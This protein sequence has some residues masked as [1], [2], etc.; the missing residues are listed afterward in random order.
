LADFDLK[1]LNKILTDFMK[2]LKVV[3]VYPDNN[4]IPFKLKESFIDRF[5]DF[6]RD[7]GDL[8]LKIEN[9]CL[10]MD[11]QTVYEEDNP[12]ESL[13]LFFHYSG[14]NE[15]SFSRTFGVD[16]ANEFFKVI[17]SFINKEEGGDDL[18]SLLWQAEIG[19][20]DYRTIED[21]TLGNYD[22][23]F[24][25]FETGS[26]AGDSG[27]I[28]T[29]ENRVQYASIFL[30]EDEFDTSD[31]SIGI[32]NELAD[33]K[34]G[35]NTAPAVK[36]SIPM[37]TAL[38][39]K[40]AYKPNDED[41][42][43]IN[44]LH[45][46]DNEFDMYQSTR[47]LLG[48]LLL[49]ENE[50][51]EFNESV[52]VL[53]KIFSDLTTAGN[54][55]A[56]AGLL[57][58]LKELETI[59]SEKSPRWSERIAGAIIL[60]GGWEGISKLASVLNDHPEIEAAEINLYLSNFG[61]QSLSAIV[62]LLGVAEHMTHRLAICDYL[63]V[64][65]REHVDIIA[66]GIVDHRWF[67]VRN[68]V[69]ILVAIGGQKAFNHLSRA[70]TH[71]EPRVRQNIVKSLAEYE[72]ERGYQLFTKLIWD[73]N[74]EVAQASLEAILSLTDSSVLNI[75]IGIINDERFS[76]LPDNFKSSLIFS[77]SQNGGEIAVD[78]L[79]SLIEGMK[80][81]T[82]PTGEFYLQTAFG[83]LAI[84]GSEKAKKELTRMTKDKNKMIKH[85]ASEALRKQAE[86]I[87]NDL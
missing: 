65:G 22:D 38:L 41:Q 77:F 11:G 39:L 87:R 15:I 24:R 66:R 1:Y 7:N 62:D 23:D 8:R 20:F 80:K 27:R 37:E 19:G 30:D 10:T 13:A 21:I 72:D 67:V 75:I 29:G 31:D 14:I 51:F 81:A 56:A 71:E 46:E 57:T 5:I 73:S 9:H 2:T 42:N 85:S 76:S 86:Y 58:D 70:V 59:L 28:D 35:L 33:E 4:P 84:N 45:A 50:Y 36:N 78:Y 32:E 68:T 16:Q 40:E 25:I 12:E 47:G 82:D 55:S 6:I 61:W 74:E 34:M 18:V 52:T 63:S 79:V 64:A 17:K 54:L 83:A 3:S 44:T 60:A 43:E 53:E 49:K 26:A 69:S 48:E